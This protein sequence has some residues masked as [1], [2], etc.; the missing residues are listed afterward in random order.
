MVYFVVYLFQPA[1]QFAF[2]AV[3]EQITIF[4]SPLMTSAENKVQLNIS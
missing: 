1:A 4:N 3:P 2:E